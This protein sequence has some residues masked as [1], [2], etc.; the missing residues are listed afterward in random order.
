[1]LIVPAFAAEACHNLIDYFTKGLG[2]IEGFFNTDNGY[3]GHFFISLLLN[4]TATSFLA[5]INNFGDLNQNYFSPYLAYNY[6]MFLA[7]SD[8]W[9][10]E[11]Y[12]VFPYGYYY[13]HS[14][15]I[16]AI[17]LVYA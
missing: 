17:T 9:R 6:R 12:E 7:D 16:F 13:S 15:A 10:K 4:S 3:Q 14:L 2:G 8:P 11:E 5:T 1:M